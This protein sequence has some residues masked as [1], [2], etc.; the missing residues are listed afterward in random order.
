MAEAVVAAVSLGAP[1]I[2]LIGMAGQILQGYHS[3]CD[4]FDD[5]NDAPKKNTVHT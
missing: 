3:I 4:C 5:I 2:S 1:V